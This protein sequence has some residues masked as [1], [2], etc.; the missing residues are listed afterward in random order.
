M[1][2]T[3]ASKLGLYDIIMIKSDQ[4]NISSRVVF[5]TIKCYSDEEYDPYFLFV[6]FVI[7]LH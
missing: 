7:Q 3:D 4:W 6:K 2:Y 1:R 5:A